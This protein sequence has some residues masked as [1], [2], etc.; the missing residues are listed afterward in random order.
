MA[1]G[2][3][4]PLR[5]GIAFVTSAKPTWAPCRS[6]DGVSIGRAGGLGSTFDFVVGDDEFGS[7]FGGSGGDELKLASRRSIHISRISL[8]PALR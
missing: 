1:P 2:L 3:I 8:S 6:W 7:A 5:S 4:H